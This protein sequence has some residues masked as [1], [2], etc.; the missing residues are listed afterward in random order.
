MSS[1]TLGL[2]VARPELEASPPGT[3]TSGPP[4]LAM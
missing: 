2:S 3:R 4:T 1:A